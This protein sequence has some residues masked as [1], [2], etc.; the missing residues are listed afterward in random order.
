MSRFRP[1]R[2]SFPIMDLGFPFQLRFI[3]MV[4]QGVLVLG[5][6]RNMLIRAPSRRVRRTARV[7]GIPRL[8]LRRNSFYIGRCSNWPIR[9]RVTISVTENPRCTILDD[10]PALYSDVTSTQ[11]R[12]GAA[13][14]DGQST[15]LLLGHLVITSRAGRIRVPE[16]RPDGRANLR[17]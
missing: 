17:I 10:G 5:A 3:L 13:P 16:S 1:K 7:A 4:L 15:S 9:G 6:D 14:H 8:T 2:N 11:P 12:K